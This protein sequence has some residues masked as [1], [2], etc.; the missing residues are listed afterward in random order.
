MRC[1]PRLCCAGALGWAP[2]PVPVLR[3]ARLRCA[4]VFAFYFTNTYMGLFF[5]VIFKNFKVLSEKVRSA[6]LPD[7]RVLVHATCS[8]RRCHARHAC[9]RTAWLPLSVSAGPCSMALRSPRWSMW[10][11]LL[12]VLR[13]VPI[14]IFR[15][16]GR[17]GSSWLSAS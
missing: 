11:W 8:M 14:M 4:Q 17:F 13:R 7:S 3:S 10:S 16:F 6:P 1:L 2:V 5:Y 12:T 15:G 9:V